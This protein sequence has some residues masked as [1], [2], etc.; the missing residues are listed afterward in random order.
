MGKS[1]HKLCAYRHCGQP[2]Q[3][4]SLKNS[5]KYCSTEHARREKAFRSGKAKDES[6]FRTPDVGIRKC[7]TCGE[8]FQRSPGEKNIRCHAC[9]EKARH[10]VCK[11]GQSFEDRSKKNTRR[12]CDSC[13]SKN[14]EPGAKVS[15]RQERRRRRR[16]RSGEG[17]RL[18]Q[19]D[20]LRPFS[21]TWWG[22]VGE[23]LFLHLH[24]DSHDAVATYGGKAYFDVE[25]RTFGRVSVKTAGKKETWKFQLTPDSDTTFLVGFSEDRS[26][27]ERA[28]LMPSKELPSRLKVMNPGSREYTEGIYELSHSELQVLNRK[29]CTFLDAA[30]A[31]KPQEIKEDVVRVEYE[32]LILGRIGELIYAHLYPQSEHISENDPLAFCDFIDPDGATVNVRLRRVNR[33]RKRW[34]FFRSLSSHAKTDF[35]FFVGLDERAQTLEMAFRVPASE[36]P[37]FGFSVSRSPSKWDRWRVNVSLPRPVSDFIQISNLED[38]HLKVSSLSKASVSDMSDGEIEELLDTAFL[39]HRTLGFPY[40]APPSDKRLGSWVE[41]VK[42]YTPKGKDLPVEN[43][44]LGFCSAYMPHRFNARNVDSD[45]SALSAFNDDDRFRKALR[46]CLKGEKPNLKR[47]A[48]RSV[49]TSLN[50][51]PVQFR[52]AVA[53]ALVEAY[54]QPG[55]IVLDPCAGWGGRFLG[56]LV[57]GRKYVGVEPVKTTTDALWRMGSRLSEF[58]EIDR[59]SFQLYESQIQTMPDG[60]VK[61]DMAFTSPP[62]WTKEVYEG[63]SP[64][65]L[66]QWVEDFLCSLF[67]KVKTCLSVGAVFAVN[68]ADIK[69]GRKVIPLEKITM[70]VAVDQGMRLKAAWRMLKTSFGKQAKDRFEPILIFECEV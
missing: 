51:T 59:S 31:W 9:R 64:V 66:D 23:L 63:N 57:I 67:A 37:D 19:L 55:G 40:P 44:A 6:Y 11:C 70:D 1:R 48:V 69:D 61:A 30:K 60:F 35:Y 49:L 29:L 20:T 34:T 17:G 42:R 8:K 10:K 22:R 3:D 12:L 36:M 41:A 39:Y 5:A 33:S 38:A 14:P 62:Y 58:L 50:R 54:T 25:H 24:P 28:W 43:A 32:R 65:P 27:I 52:P 56:T 13:F 45:F 2:F 53:K 68:I 46:F 16:V 15:S 7:Q 21:T 47:S 18:D 4:T 26:C